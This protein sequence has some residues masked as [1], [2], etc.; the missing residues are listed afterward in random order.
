[1][2]TGAEGAEAGRRHPA[3]TG[4]KKFTFA[5]G[6]AAALGLAAFGASH[7]GYWPFQGAVAQAPRQN[8]PRAVPVDVAR[9]V[10]KKVPVRVDLLGTVT[11]IRSVA[12]KTRVDTEI[13]EVHFS[14]GAMVKEGDL[15]FSLDKRAI[16]A[17]IKQ[18]EGVLAAARAQREQAMRDVE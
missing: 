14:D 12:V 15:L 13:T 2:A 17:Q 16:E 3:G 18:T 7:W 8:T 1:G 5:A 11:P 9:A 6:V 10:K 4:M